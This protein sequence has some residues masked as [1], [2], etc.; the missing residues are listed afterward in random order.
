MQRDAEHSRIVL[1]IL[2][3]IDQDGGQSQRKQASEIGIALGLINAYLKFCPQEL[4]QSPQGFRS[5]LSLYAYPQGFCH[6]D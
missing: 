4:S 6:R 3:S 1:N 5:H 2:E